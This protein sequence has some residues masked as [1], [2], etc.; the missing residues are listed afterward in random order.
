MKIGILG[1]TA[2]AAAMGR[3]L[4][5]AGN[6]VCSG[7]VGDEASACEMLIFAGLRDGA[8]DVITQLGA[9]K[10]VIVDAMEGAPPIDSHAIRVLFQTPKSGRRVFVSGDD[11]DS[12]ALVNDVFRTAGMVTRY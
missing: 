1:L 6:D 3:L 11:A 10:T 9:T 4:L 12:V 7:D 2:R 8:D 5:D